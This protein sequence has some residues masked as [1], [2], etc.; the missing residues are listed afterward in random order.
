MK[1][2]SKKVSSLVV[3]GAIVA[4]VLGFAQSAQADVISGATITLGT[5]SGTSSTS[6]TNA[7][8]ASISTS[9]GCPVGYRASSGTVAWQGG[10]SKGS[11]ATVRTPSTT[12]YGATGLDGNAINMDSSGG[13]NPYV[14]NKG[15]SALTSPL[16]AGNWEL[17]V[18]CFASSTTPDY[19]TDK[20]MTLAMTLDGSGN[21]AVYVAPAA[22]ENT[23]ASL[24][25]GS[26][27]AAGTV[28][29]AVTVKK[30]DLTTAT[31]AVGNV[32]FLEGSTVLATVTLA[33]GIALYTTPVVVDG[34][35]IYTAQFVTT[36]AAT[37]ASSPLSGTASV[38]VGGQ[39]STTVIDLTIPSGVGSLTFTGVPSTVTLGT[40]VLTGGE[41][42]ATGTLGTITVTDSRQ[43]GSVAWS[44][45][46]QSTDFTVG[47]LTISGKY[48]GWTP[49]L[50]GSSNA[51]TAGAAVV[52]GTG[53]SN[54][55]L[56]TVS[57]L[58]IAA[59]PVDGK[60]TTA[61]SAGLRLAAPANTPAGRYTAT[62]TVTLI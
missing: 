33:S 35:H 54:T 9:T 40:A 60:P 6:G 41:L 13:P 22:A 58:A 45:T 44:L 7:M 15:L 10:V 8:F 28:N 19:A 53:N 48:L 23:I 26:G 29:L 21:W 37:Y 27:T 59:G 18:Y 52:A 31:A 62:L 17:R 43:L 30:T 25:A 38:L 14:N 4:G 51:G 50:V 24:T 16:T 61:V 32:Q 5:T 11:L 49:A 46:G 55:G 3:V 36:N 56:R 2:M 47:G 1:R 42:V 12:L 39:T 57:S 20:Y 34:L